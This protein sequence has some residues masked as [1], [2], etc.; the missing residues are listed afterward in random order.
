[1][2]LIGLTSMVVEQT[3]RFDKCA[4]HTVHSA[5][6]N[7][8]FYLRTPRCLRLLACSCL[9]VGLLCMVLS[10]FVLLTDLAYLVAR[11]LTRF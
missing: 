2:D 3:D 7:D 11:Q 10:L 1:M 5:Q 9:F 8:L 4:L 6:C